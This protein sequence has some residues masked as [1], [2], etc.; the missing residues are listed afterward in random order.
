MVDQ[1]NLEED[2]ILMNTEIDHY[3]VKNNESIED[4]NG[5]E[6]KVE[7]FKGIIRIYGINKKG[8]SVLV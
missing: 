4:E 8:N 1:I 3:V 7:T 5:D 2:F 6:Q